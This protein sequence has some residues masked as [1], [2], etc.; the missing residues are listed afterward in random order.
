[1]PLKKTSRRGF[2]KTLASYT[3]SAGMASTAAAQ[4]KQAAPETAP[5]CIVNPTLDEFDL[6]R[7]AEPAF[8]FKA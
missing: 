4:E 5:P 2:G 3:A 6:P 7:D 1:M 8:T